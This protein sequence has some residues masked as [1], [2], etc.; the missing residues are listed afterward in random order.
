MLSARAAARLLAFKVP[1]LRRV[2]E[3]RWELY[4]RNGELTRLV[5]TLQNER[6]QQREAVLD[7]KSEKDALLLERSALL[8][9]RSLTTRLMDTFENERDLLS[10]EVARLTAESRNLQENTRSSL[11]AVIEDIWKLLYLRVGPQSAALMS[12]QEVATRSILRAIEGQSGSATGKESALRRKYLDLLELALTGMI[13]GDAPS[14]PSSS[15]E[16]DRGIRTT[17]RDWP[18]QAHTMVGLT[19]LRNLRDLCERVIESGVPGDF[20]E[21]GVW[22]GGACILMRGVLNSYNDSERR[23]FVADSFEGLPPPNPQY[24]ADVGDAHYTYREL[25]ISREDVEENF[26]RY[27]LLDEQVIFLEGWFRDTL[28]TAPIEKLSILRLDGDM[29]ESTIQALEALYSKVSPGGFI[30]I[31]DYILKPCARAVDEFR[32]KHSIQTK[33]HN[34]DDAAV[35]WRVGD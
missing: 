3:D 35:W 27:G 7:L 5:T 16:Y 31:D 28:Q 22:R 4:L 33:M 13:Y 19:R 18:S 10:Q 24:E 15:G 2:L 1:P 23:V 14:E 20:I 25:A 34:V 6:D 29:Y 12:N 8:E 21:T 26:R 11:D 30:I 9:E 32:A 17:G